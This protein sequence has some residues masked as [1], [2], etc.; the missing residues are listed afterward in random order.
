MSIAITSRNRPHVLEYSL[1]KTREHY[2]GFIVVIDDNSDTK[3]HNESICKKYDAAHFYNNKRLGIPNSKARGFIALLT[4]SHQYWFDDDCFLKAPL[5]RIIEAQE[6]QPHLLY[7]KKW[8]HVV[9]ITT[10][11]NG[12]VQYSGATACFMSFTKEIYPEVH[13]FQVG[14]GLY[15]GWHHKLS[16]KLAGGYF[17]IENA[18]EYIGSF[19]IDKP[20]PDFNYNFGSSLPKHERIKKKKI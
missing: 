15:G 17:A 13:G 8:A 2:D 19:D 11:E 16:L 12:I 7:L 20:P 6:Y 9:P 1:S 14:H 10:P 3:A 18:Q 5:D 4:F